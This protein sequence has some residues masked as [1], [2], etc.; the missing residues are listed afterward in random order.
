MDQARPNYA[1]SLPRSCI[2]AIKLHLCLHI[3]EIHGTVTVWLR[4]VAAINMTLV[5]AVTSVS[6]YRRLCRDQGMSYYDTR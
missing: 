3:N 1:S 6:R 2:R 4:K 5:A